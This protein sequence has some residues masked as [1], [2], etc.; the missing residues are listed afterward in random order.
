[1]KTTSMKRLI[2]V[3]LLAVAVAASPAL[4]ADGK[5]LYESKCAMCHGMDGVPK[6]MGAGSKHFNDPAWKKG[7]TVEGIVKITHEGKGKMKGMKDKINDA[8]AKAIAEYILTL[9][10]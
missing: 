4:A 7:E 3:T 9:A 10:K 5:A 8:D 2:P 1:M 6:K